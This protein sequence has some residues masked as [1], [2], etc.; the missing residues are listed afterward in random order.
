VVIIN[1]SQQTISL[2]LRVVNLTSSAQQCYKRR[3]S[4]AELWSI[5]AADD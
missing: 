4:E 1:K 2:G 5:T 3:L